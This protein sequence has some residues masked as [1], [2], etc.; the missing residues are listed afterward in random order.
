[1]EISQRN[2][3]IAHNA[4]WLYFRMGINMFIV[5]FS[6]RLILKNLGVE[7]Y[8][9][10]NLL[11][12]IVTTFSCLSGALASAGARFIA[13]VLG[14]GNPENVRPLFSAYCAI[15][16][17]LIV[18]L[19]FLLETVGTFFVLHRVHIPAPLLQDGIFFYHL[20]TFAFLVNL[21]II[22]CNSMFIAHEDMNF[23]AYMSIFESTGKLI[24]AFLLI[25][26]EGGKVVFYGCC[27]LALSLI[28]SICCWTIC[29]RQYP[30]SHFS[31]SLIR[32]CHQKKNILLF[33][34]WRLVGS[35][36]WSLSDVGSSVL[37]N[38]F[39]GLV[40]NAA[41]AISMQVSLAIS[42]S[43]QN[44]FMAVNPQIVKAWAGDEKEYF[45]QLIMT[46]QKY[47]F[48]VLYF[49]AIPFLFEIQFVLHLWLNNVP[50]YSVSFTRLIVIS[51]LIDL[52]SHPLN[53]GIQATGHICG[54]EL[55]CGFVRLLV[56]PVGYI[57]LRC[58]LSGSWVIGLLIF[59]A[60]INVILRTI[61][62]HKYSK[63]SLQ[64]IFHK[65][66]RP[67]VSVIIPSL[68][69]IWLVSAITS[70]RRWISFFAVGGS[71]VL[72]NL[73]LIYF[74][75]LTQTERLGIFQFIKRKIAR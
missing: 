42:S 11:S 38:N 50:E 55:S 64:E 54:M 60:T 25:F 12:S 73:C 32:Q 36:A 19:G 28:R 51:I 62:L 17:F 7:E 65:V 2:K 31:F 71:S 41:R 26:P 56:L 33:S 48:F 46:S 59:S 16:L 69:L 24:I 23:L 5:F 22:P 34:G 8:G 61:I 45:N 21:S 4:F 1:M 63:I 68:L 10:V 35:I 57:L 29:Y 18:V 66:F 75:G 40:A 58:G 52:F 67:I 37:I 9:L 44:L 27:L 6:T 43:F 15:F 47:G 30:E 53:F 14:E 49:V 3:K 70:N 72:I 74:I 20:A 13:H 39:C